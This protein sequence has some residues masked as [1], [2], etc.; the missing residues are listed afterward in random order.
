MG[1]RCRHRTIA[2]GVQRV[3]GDQVPALPFVKKDLKHPTNESLLLVGYT[4]TNAS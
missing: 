3:K 1:Y 2:V 4:R